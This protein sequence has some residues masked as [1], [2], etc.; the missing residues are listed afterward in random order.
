[1]DRRKVTL[2]KI[3]LYDLMRMVEDLYSQGADF[4]DITGVMNGPNKQDEV[5][6]SVRDEYMHNEDDDDDDD[7]E[8][9]ANIEYEEEEH[10]GFSGVATEMEKTIVNADFNLNDLLNAV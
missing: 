8:D 10:E 3:P 4:I 6:L 9:E 5:S 2:K 7:Y 1:M